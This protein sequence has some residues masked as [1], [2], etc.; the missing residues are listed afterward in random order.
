MGAG[1]DEVDWRLQVC[2]AKSAAAGVKFLRPQSEFRLSIAK[3]DANVLGLFDDGAVRADVFQLP[4]PLF[5]R[6]GDDLAVDDAHHVPY[7]L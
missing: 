2:N 1:L 6:H 7:C 4:S 3:A 5:Q